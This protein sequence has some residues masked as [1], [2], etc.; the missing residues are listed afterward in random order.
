MAATTTTN[1]IEELKYTYSVDQVQYL[2]SEETVTYNIFKKKPKGMGGRGQWLEPLTVQNPI[3][4]TGIAESGALP[5]TVAADTAEASFAL[6][7]YVAS[8]GVSWKLIQDASKKKWAFAKAVDYMN[9]GL[10]RGFLRNL[11]ADIISTGRGELFRLPAGDDQTTITVAEVPSAMQGQVVDVM[12]IS[13][14]TTALAD[15][16]TVSGVDPIGLTVTLGGAPTGS[17]ADDYGVIQDTTDGAVCLHMNGLLGIVD[18]ANPAT[19][20]GNYG[21][22]NRSTAGN[23]FWQAVELGNSGTNRSLTEDLIL[24]AL[25]GMRVKGGGNCDIILSND[26]I[27]RRYHELLADER[28]MTVSPGKFV[29]GGV[30]PQGAGKMPKGDG[31]TVYSFGGVAWH[32]DPFFHANTIV[33]LDTSCFYLAHGDGAPVPRPISELM[34]GFPFFRQTSNATAEVVWYVQNELVC[35]KPSAQAKIVDVSES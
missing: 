16:Q 32:V 18:S 29:R 15:S 30:G 10:K 14:D 25:D 3:N 7:E 34:P 24:Q 19:V 28:W 4:V 9:D 12:D 5:T 26:P 21:G 8:Y 20:V 33:L 11:N 1:V 31:K 22:V 17:A 13:D 6:Q 35:T 27:K 2:F 23:E